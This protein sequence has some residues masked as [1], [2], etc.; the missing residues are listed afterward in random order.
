MAEHF[1]TLSADPKVPALG[2]FLQRSVSVDV[3]GGYMFPSFD[4]MF[5]G[6]PDLLGGALPA[7][8]G[9]AGGGRG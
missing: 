8:P 1:G 5:L 9:V 2:N 6:C 7:P 3:P 4:G